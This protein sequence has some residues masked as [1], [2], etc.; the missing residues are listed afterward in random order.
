M[1]NNLEGSNH[2]HVEQLLACRLPTDNESR[3]GLGRSQAR[4]GLGPRLHDFPVDGLA[5]V[6]TL[7]REAS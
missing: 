3:L 5:W 1:V 6:G 7:G 4:H 2:D